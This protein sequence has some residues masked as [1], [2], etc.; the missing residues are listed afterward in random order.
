M[1]A[2]HFTPFFRLAELFRHVF[3]IPIS[4]GALVKTIGRVAKKA[5]PA[6]EL[7]RERVKVAPVNGGDETGMKINGD[8]GWFW[9]FQGRLFTFIIASLN[10]GSQTIN[11]HFPKG[12]NFSVLVNDC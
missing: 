6:Y 7:I 11:E 4:E 2:R 9:T 5:I 10:R 1:S 12:F 8:K 3:N